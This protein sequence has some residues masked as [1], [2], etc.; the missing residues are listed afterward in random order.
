MYNRGKKREDRDSHAEVYD[1][2]YQARKP[3]SADEPGEGQ[4]DGDVER[5]RGQ[6]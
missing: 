6:D 2:L 1:L 4:L 3:H 5:G